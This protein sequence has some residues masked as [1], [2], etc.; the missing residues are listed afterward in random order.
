M[1]SPGPWMQQIRLLLLS[2]IHPYSRKIPHTACTQQGISLGDT[3]QRYWGRDCRSDHG[4]RLIKSEKDI[5]LEVGGVAA[6][7]LEGSPRLI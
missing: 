4:V 1:P 6:D 5:D 7:P 3:T 2:R